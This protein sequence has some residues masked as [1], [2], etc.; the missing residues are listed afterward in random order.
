MRLRLTCLA[1]AAVLGAMASREL[2]ARER[3]PDATDVKIRLMSEALEA[4]DTGDFQVA[5]TKLADLARLAP[6]DPQITRLIQSVERLQQ[7]ALHPTPPPPPPAPIGDSGL[8][9]A[10]APTATPQPAPTPDLLS[11]PALPAISDLATPSQPA[12][13]SRLWRATDADAAQL[14]ADETARLNED[15]VRVERRLAHARDLIA[16]DRHR[17]ALKELR[18]IESVLPSNPLTEPLRQKI[19]AALV[20]V[21]HRLRVAA[22]SVDDIP[23]VLSIQ[24]GGA[25]STEA[26]RPA[27]AYSPPL[28]IELEL[29]EVPNA[30]VDDVRAAWAGL[31]QRARERRGRILLDRNGR[32]EYQRPGRTLLSSDQVRI[33]K[34]IVAGSSKESAAFAPVSTGAMGFSANFDPDLLVRTLAA[35]KG[36]R[37]LASPRLSVE[38]GEP[39][40][41]TLK[42]QASRSD[43]AVDADARSGRDTLL[44]Q[45]KVVMTPTVGADARVDG[46]RFDLQAS[47]YQGIV[48]QSPRETRTEQGRRTDAQGPAAET[49]FGGARSAGV[50]RLQAGETLVLVGMPQGFWAGSAFDV[51]SPLD[52]VPLLGRWHRAVALWNRDRDMVLIV[53]ILP[54]R[55]PIPPKA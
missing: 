31:A 23:P 3:K 20:D 24:Y 1:A 14:A 6:N 12:A 9:A 8:P 11:T 38:A 21:E 19:S 16:E 48:S 28:D 45:W 43:A 30:V 37:L 55:H 15:M 25:A 13:P 32:P 47:S 7:A 53:R 51:R 10:P 33:Y 49:I 4:R 27:D 18:Q 22:I 52:R 50:A 2:Q 44:P 42:T 29:L 17:E 39:T 46:L 26:A 54:A 40:T 5:L 35:M 34:A 36:C 41:L